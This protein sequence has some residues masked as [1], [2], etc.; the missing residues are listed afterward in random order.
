MPMPH[1]DDSSTDAAALR[2]EIDRLRADDARLRELLDVA[3]DFGRLGVWERDPNTLEGRWDRHVFRFFGFAEGATPHF[4][5]AA[6]R[7]D[8]DDQLGTAFLESLKVPGV[9][10]HRYRVR[11]PDGTVAHMHSQWRVVAGSDGRAS[12]VIGVMVD[13][14]DAHRLADEVATANAQLNLALDLSA[15]GLWRYD[16]ATGRIHYDDRA[17]DMLDRRMGPE[18]VPIETVRSWVHPDDRAEVQA[19]FEKSLSSDKPVDTQTRYLHGDGR[20]RTI[21]TRRV[22]RRDEAGR[23]LSLIGVGVDITEQQERTL[24]SLRLARRLESAAEAA[25]VGLWSGAMRDETPEWNRLMFEL[26]G[27]DPAAGPLRLGDGLRRYTHPEDRDR[28]ARDVLAWA[29]GPDDATLDVEVRVVRGDGEVRWMVVRSRKEQGPDGILRAFGI[30]LDVTEQR[31]AVGRLRVE[32]ERVT[33]ALSSVGMGTWSHDIASDHSEW[34]AQM[35]RLRGLEPTA[36]APSAAERMAMVL[37]EDRAHVERETAKLTASGEPTH[38]EFRIRRTDGEVRTLASR[39]VGLVDAKGRLERRIGVNWDVTEARLLERAQQERE[40]ALRDSRTKTAL[41][42]RMSHELRTPLNAILGMTQLML[43]EPEG[44]DANQRRRRI[45]QMQTAGE[46]LLSLVDG[47]LEL[48]E[49]ADVPRTGA[50]RPLALRPVVERAVTT[51]RQRLGAERVQ[52]HVEGQAIEA[53]ADERAIERVMAQ[54]LAHAG[55]RSVQGGVVRVDL[56]RD[57]AESVIA[58]SDA[59]LAITGERAQRLFEAFGDGAAAEARTA[60]GALG[61]ALA[62]AHALRMG[63]RVRLV[64]SD[65]AAT[66]LELRLPAVLD[67]AIQ[68]GA[69]TAAMR[70]LY[71]EDNDVNMM[72]VRELL[73]QR[74]GISFHGACDGRHG[75]ALAHELLPALVLVDMQ[76]PDIDGIEVLRR[77]RADPA[78]A[79]LRCIALSANAMPEDLRRARA[80]GFDD[81]WTKP[82][83]LSAFLA[84]ID[85]LVPTHAP[86]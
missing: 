55:Q 77:L 75:L 16:F 42:S 40:M 8:P 57:G 43:A 53:M 38:Y 29:H 20:W 14:S 46:D 60:L 51:A 47:V 34:D 58:V 23:P 56:R 33:L 74:P 17:Q 61:L 59:G 9:H 5:E 65:A 37:A 45:A 48:N 18:G 67:A 3:Q 63:G 73:A 24:E 4:E 70:I 49:L 7:I 21:L 28:V 79:A 30:L 31:E 54:L 13:D 15:I 36:H 44:G 32:H 1:P 83:D 64:R 76:L 39:S 52:I 11:R 35:F 80:A 19:A 71:I 62:H 81:Y 50:V 82:I 10:G 22:V 85:R 66:T 25:R 6:A 12:R 27:H 2:A 86:A 84:A 26:L 68:H 41:L 72:I 69:P 78:T